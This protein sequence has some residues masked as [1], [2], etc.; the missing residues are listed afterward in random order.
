MWYLKNHVIFSALQNLTLF[1]QFLCRSLLN[2]P[3]NIILKKMIEKGKKYCKIGRKWAKN[4]RF[5]VLE[6]RVLTLFSQFSQIT[7]KHAKNIILKNQKNSFTRKNFKSEKLQKW[8]KKA[9]KLSFFDPWRAEFWPFFHNF[10]QI[11]SKYAQKH[12]IK[13]S[14]NFIH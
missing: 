8:P 13:K 7:S 11:T 1:S 12:H 14:E 6:G 2:I 10:L 9:K 3:R 4:C 5:L